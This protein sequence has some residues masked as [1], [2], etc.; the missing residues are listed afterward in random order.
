MHVSVR[1][2]NVFMHLFYEPHDRITFIVDISFMTFESL[3]TKSLEKKSKNSIS[4]I[5][6]LFPNLTLFYA[7][8][9]LFHEH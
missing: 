8:T 6:F 2:I 5:I 1:L 7:I 4:N 9:E 3:D